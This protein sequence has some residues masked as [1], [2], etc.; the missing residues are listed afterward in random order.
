MISTINEVHKQKWSEHIRYLAHA[1][2]CT[3]HDVTGFQPFYLM[4]MRYP[5]LKVDWLFANDYEQESRGP[6]SSR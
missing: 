2:N 3:K 5:R 6:S 4:C 1:Y